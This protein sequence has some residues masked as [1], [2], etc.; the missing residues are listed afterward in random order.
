MPPPDLQ[1]AWREARDW[2]FDEA[3]P[4][5]AEVGMDPAGGFHDQIGDDRRPIAAPK[6]L[7]VQ[8]RQMFVYAEAARLGWSGPWREVIRHGLA[9]FDAH[10][11]KDGLYPSQFE[12]GASRGCTLY[13][14]AFVLLG[15]AHARR[16]LDEPAHEARAAAFLADVRARLGR[17]DGGFD[18][19]DG[20]DAPLQSNPHMHLYEACL[21]W[22]ALSPAEPWTSTAATIR[23]LALGTFIDPAS[24]R[25]G[26]YF[27]DD[28]ARAPGE[29]GRVAE[30][31]HQ[32]E[33][34]SLL[35]IDG[36]QDDAVAERLIR[37]A[38]DTGVDRARE[39][40]IFSQD[41]ETGAPIDASARLWSQTERLRAC[42]L[43]R[44]RTGDAGYWTDEALKAYAALQKYLQTP[45]AG[46]WRDRMD[47]DGGL[48]GEPA[49]AS[50]LYHV[51]GA[52]AVL[53][54]AAEGRL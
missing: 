10:A 18:E 7:R 50:S 40:A 44:G 51:M 53:K 29:A 20:G 2:L 14:Q 36:R 21:A 5:W 27:A 42:L 17:P 31:G 4:L 25:L 39:V 15:L 3:L 33:W 1:A 35:M 19:V 46:L 37:T 47:L 28:G 30:P 49:K 52:Y 48:D 23:G 38:T 16:A 24:G 34:A 26:E 6:R 54:D 13:D 8:G 43:L 22:R 32:Y 45:G 41:I 12:N 11:P 9:F